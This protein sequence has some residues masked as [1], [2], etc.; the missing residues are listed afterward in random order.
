MFTK[1]HNIIIVSSSARA[2]AQSVSLSGPAIYT[3]DQF[4]DLE[5]SQKKHKKLDLASPQFFNN[6]LEYFKFLAL[7]LMN[8]KI[9]LGSGME[10][11]V[12]SFS[13]LSEY[14]EVL[15]N[16]P[17]NYEICNN[18]KVF[19]DLLTKLSIKHPTSSF[20]KPENDYMWLQKS[21]Y[22][23]GGAH[24][25]WLRN[26]KEQ[27]HDIYYQKYIHGIPV[28]ILFLSDGLKHSVVGI[29]KML[30]NS[31]NLHHPFKYTGAISDFNVN[32]QNISLINEIIS[33]LVTTL[34]LVGLNGI[35]CII[36]DDLYVLECNPRLTATCELYSPRFKNGYLYAHMHAAKGKMYRPLLSKKQLFYGHRILYATKSFILPN[37]ITWPQWIHDIPQKGVKIQKYLPLCS[38][39]ASAE[40]QQLLEEK[41]EK[42]A[43]LIIDLIKYCK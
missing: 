41:L 27:Q 38:I 22:S 34:K 16:T 6:L 32:M 12:S 5:L 14:G 40:N 21:N 42:R 17:N 23:N 7:P 35:D 29:S 2:H 28:S 43:M 36:N 10:K 4:S 11:W 13:L 19:F 24:V 25:Q 20:S 26:A 31:D 39:F 8:T 37:S 18:H 3:V 30:S 1:N 33:K 15:G 9:I